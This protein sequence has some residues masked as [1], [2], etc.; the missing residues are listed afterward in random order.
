MQFTL[1]KLMLS[2]IPIAFLSW[3]AGELLR[4]WDLRSYYIGF[5]DQY[6]VPP[7]ATGTGGEPI[8]EA[9]GSVMA[10][11]WL[12]GPWPAVAIF[13]VAAAIYGA[14]VKGGSR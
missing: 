6:H 12:F 5:Y 4:H 3:C 11:V 13:S 14:Q 8:S 7:W 1:R 9:L 2:F 10:I